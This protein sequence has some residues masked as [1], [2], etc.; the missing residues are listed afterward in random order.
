MVNKIKTGISQAID[1]EFNIGDIEYEI[2]SESI[3][4]GFDE[5]CFF[6]TKLTSSEKQIVGNSY[7]FKSSW[8]IQY[9]PSNEPVDGI[10]KKNEECDNVA[11]ILTA[12]MKQI[13][14]D[15]KFV[16]GINISNETI[17]S[18]LHFYVD[19]N[20]KTKYDITQADPMGQMSSN[21][22]IT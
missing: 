21:I 12:I 14:V 22:N 3:E 19:Y 11:T 18:V 20:L 6:I 9:F 17:D 15:S 2:Y 1:A 5:P 7:D 13:T 16:R 8:D 10:F 4:Q